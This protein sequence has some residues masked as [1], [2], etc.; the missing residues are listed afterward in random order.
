LKRWNW[1]TKASCWGKAMRRRALI[2]RSQRWLRLA[3]TLSA[4]QP[5]AAHIAKRQQLARALGLAEPTTDQFFIGTIAPDQIFEAIQPRADL[6]LVPAWSLSFEEQPE[7]E[8]AARFASEEPEQITE[9]P[10]LDSSRVEEEDQGQVSADQPPVVADQETLEPF[11][12]MEPAGDDP[13]E[14][15]MAARPPQGG[16]L[17]VA[18][19]LVGVGFELIESAAPDIEVGPPRLPTAEAVSDPAGSVKEPAASQNTQEQKRTESHAPVVETVKAK[20]RRGSV[21]EQPV[22]IDQARS[23]G[24]DSGSEQGKSATRSFKTSMQEKEQEELAAD[25]LFAPRGTDRSPQA[26]LARLRG[27]M[28]APRESGI[29]SAVE[30]VKEQT[31]LLRRSGES[32]QQMNQPRAAVSGQL[33]RDAG[34]SSSGERPNI[35][36]SGA[37]GV[38]EQESGVRQPLTKA[39]NVVNEKA[40]ARTDPAPLSQ[41]TRRFLRPLLGID[42]ANVPVYRDT[43][44]GRLA[45]AYQADA[46]TVGERVEVAEGHP[47]DT[48][49]TLGL[50]AHEFTHVARQH[51]PRFVPPVARPLPDQASSMREEALAQRVEGRVWRA[52]QARVDQV[53]PS[54]LEPV[55]MA[56]ASTEMEAQSV[57]A[58]RAQPDAWGGLPAP[59]EPLPGWLVELDAQSTNGGQAAAVAI[60]PVPASLATGAGEVYEGSA[61]SAV[62]RAGRERS[63]GEE[64]EQPDASLPRPPVTAVQAP[65]PDL[66]E[67]A[68]QVYTLLKRRLSVEYRRER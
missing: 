54:M 43:I 68:R 51:E 42:P 15:D 26:W 28:D 59:W 52:A 32:K 65:E 29:S 48:P 56:D 44:A 57:S 22:G 8:G 45:D 53:V 2:A 58:S 38:R 23:F 13:S 18:A 55:D 20:R 1:R 4:R 7:D 63:V 64:E 31:E 60:Q 17:H 25:A 40:Q 46:I 24:K 66:D 47:D 35:V 36:K 37:G 39:V 67:L 41:G 30:Q 14:I 9:S 11:G 33:A 27:A 34:F 19:P 3:R 5:L 62:Q 10:L 21:Q 49:E 6:V 16:T 50:L 61:T 12:K